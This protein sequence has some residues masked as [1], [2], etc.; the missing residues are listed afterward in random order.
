[1][2]NADVIVLSGAFAPIATERDFDHLEVEGD[3]PADLNGVYVRNGPNRK[4]AAEGRY[5]WFDGDGMLHA[6]YFDRGKVRYRNRWIM[7]DGLKEELD[8]GRALWQGVKEA[9]RRD[10]QDMPLKCTSN[11]D[12]K[13]WAGN[14]ISMWYLGGAVY[15][16]GADDLA[17][18]GKLNGDPRLSGLPISA[19]SKVDE[20]TG[21]LCFFAYGKTPPYMWYGSL[22]RTGNVTNF[23]PVATPGPRLPHD[24]AITKN[25]AVLHDFPLFYDMKA[26]AS[27]RH[28]L[29]FHPDMPTRFAVVPRKG[30]EADIRWFEAKPTFMYHVSNAWEESDGQGGTEIVMTGTPFRVPRDFT[31]KMDPDRMA[32]MIGLLFNDCQFYEW[33]M[34]LRTGETRERPLDDITNSEF[35]VINSAM[36]GEKTRYSWQLL[37]GRSNEPEHPRFSGLARFDLATG[38]SQTYNEGPNKWWSEAPFAPADNPKAEDDGYLVGFVWDGDQK[39]SKVYVMDAR[40]LSKG[41][42][43]KI[44]LPEIVPNG[45]HATWVSQKR[46]ARGW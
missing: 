13:Y 41:P 5:H 34:N 28:K 14:L 24:M 2:E 9:P 44:T 32:K 1:M 17:T 6:V 37:M 4:F 15:K 45:F 46:L 8:A 7:T 21:E 40:N 11:T 10:R 16:L 31:G 18:K 22:D 20:Q 26:M 35:P 3:V 36:Q 25:Y 23:M 38:A 30:T 39:K 33:R 12:V 42:V 43:C 27:K 29:E 19:H